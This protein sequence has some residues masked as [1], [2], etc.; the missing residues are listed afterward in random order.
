[1]SYCLLGLRHHIVIGCHNDYGNVS[2]LSTA[3]THGSECLVTR[4]IQEC[5][6]TAIFQLNIIGAYVLSYTAG[7]TG[8][9][10]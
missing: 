10:I 1:M 8:Y 6:V 2:N 3:G 4:S 9:Y 5:Y 7:L